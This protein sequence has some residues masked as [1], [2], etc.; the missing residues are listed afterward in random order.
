MI[1][2]LNIK[3]DTKLSQTTSQNIKDLPRNQFL[4]FIIFT[5]GPNIS[6]LCKPL[7]KITP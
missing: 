6:A 5:Y 4:K 2:I 1:K 7:K 3:D